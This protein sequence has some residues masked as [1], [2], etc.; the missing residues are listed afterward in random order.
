MLDTSPAARDRVLG[1]HVNYENIMRPFLRG[2]GFFTFF[3]KESFLFL[4]SSV[5]R[6]ALYPQHPLLLFFVKGRIPKTWRPSHDTLDKI[7]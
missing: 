4:S 3:P 5:K 7:G 2:L 1:R 6:K